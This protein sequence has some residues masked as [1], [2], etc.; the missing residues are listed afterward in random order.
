MKKLILILAACVVALTPQINA[1]SILTDSALS[2]AETR[3]VAIQD[4]AQS[5]RDSIIGEMRHAV[6]LW[7]GSY[8]ENLATVT[9]LG[10]TKTAQS[11][12]LFTGF[13]GGVRALLVSFGDTSAVA[14]VDALLAQVPAHTT[15]ANGII[16]LTAPTPEPEP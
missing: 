11:F 14:Q 2:P 3:A 13:A 6:G 9:A 4:N 5:F 8:E 16:T 10:P 12:A 1:Q 7:S 15:D